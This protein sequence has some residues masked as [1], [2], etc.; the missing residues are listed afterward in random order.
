MSQLKRYACQTGKVIVGVPLVILFIVFLI[1]FSTIAANFLAYIILKYWII[2][3][4]CCLIVIVFILGIAFLA[5]DEIFKKY[6]IC[7]RF[8]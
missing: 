1:V 5:G 7:Q 2:G 3:A 8:K 6:N 4:I